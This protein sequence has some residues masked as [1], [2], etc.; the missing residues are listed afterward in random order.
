M[1]TL[2]RKTEVQSSG[3]IFLERQRLFRCGTLQ[4]AGLWT[5]QEAMDIA[6]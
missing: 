4:Q 6:A 2:N 5:E 3:A 1:A